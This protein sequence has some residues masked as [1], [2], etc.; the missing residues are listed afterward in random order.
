MTGVQTCALPISKC[1]L[2]LFGYQPKRCIVEPAKNISKDL[3]E[4]IRGGLEDGKLSCVTAWRIAKDLGVRKM[5]ISSEIG[6]A[7]CRERV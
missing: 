2:G 5:E 7:S 1:Q 4:G 3:E 6:R